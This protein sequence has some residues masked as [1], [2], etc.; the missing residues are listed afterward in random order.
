MTSRRRR[1][2]STRS[3]WIWRAVVRPNVRL[4]CCQGHHGVRGSDTH[5][6]TRRPL[7]MALQISRT[8]FTVFAR[9]LQSQ[10]G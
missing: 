10:R 7:H 6:S 4:T 9:V 2:P 8:A 1:L 5:S 3:A